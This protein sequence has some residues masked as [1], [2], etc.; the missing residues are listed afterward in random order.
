MRKLALCLLTLALLTLPT[1]A[2]QY[3]LLRDYV[4]TRNGTAVSGASVQVYNPNTTT[5]PT[6]YTDI[7]GTTLATFPLTTDANGKYECYLRDGVFDLVITHTGWAISDTL[8]NVMVGSVAT[9]GSDSDSLDAY[10]VGAH[11]L[12]L[13][14][15]ATDSLER[16][17]V[18]LPLNGTTWVTRRGYVLRVPN[19]DGTNVAEHF[20]LGIG[21]LTGKIDQWQFWEDQQITFAFAQGDS[22]AADTTGL[23]YVDRPVISFGRRM[24]DSAYTGKDTTRCDAFQSLNINNDRGSRLRW[25]WAPRGAASDTI[26]YDRTN[27]YGTPEYAIRLQ[28]DLPDSNGTGGDR[29]LVQIRWWMTPA[30]GTLKSANSS[31]LTILEHNTEHY[32]LCRDYFELRPGKDTSTNKEIRFHGGAGE[33]T[34]F[35]LKDDESGFQMYV[36]GGEFDLLEA[37]TSGDS[38]RV[39]V[40]RAIVDWLTIG[41]IT[42][43]LPSTAV[44]DNYGSGTIIYRDI[45]TADAGTLFVWD[46]DD[47]KWHY[48]VEDG[49]LP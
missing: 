37:G 16:G 46:S 32:A 38:V 10:Y 21:G 39:D 15:T 26:K 35:K 48:F 41:E 19:Y 42:G 30:S 34:R 20:G 47:D 40:N 45:N 28:S 31:F 27:P 12:H 22:A 2:A 11:V 13:G 33:P 43:P 9:V 6:A 36:T 29:D 18:D 1:N 4:T 14:S 44:A 24:D 17:Y 5:N 7:N 25:I 23:R 3:R 49:V 8:D